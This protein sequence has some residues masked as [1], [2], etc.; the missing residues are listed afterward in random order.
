MTE[1]EIVV[2]G[3]ITAL[4][5]Y[6]RGGSSTTSLPQRR[7]PDD[8]V[9][10]TTLLSRGHYECGSLDQEPGSGIRRARPSWARAPRRPG[11]AGRA[12]GHDPAR[13]APGTGK[14]HLDY[15]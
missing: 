3:G 13:P 1:T 5:G 14:S 7:A 9:V 6:R 12:H 10:T 15:H 2:P 8:V 4:R 11:P